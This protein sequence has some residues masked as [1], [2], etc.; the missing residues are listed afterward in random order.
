MEESFDP[1][2]LLRARPELEFWPVE[3][4]SAHRWCVFDPLTRQSYHVGSEE[5][6]LLT[7]GRQPQT[8][9][10]LMRSFR[11]A[12][13][14]YRG[15]DRELAEL[16]EQLRSVGLLRGE[17]LS[18]SGGSHRS[19]ANL[20]QKLIFFQV[21]GV[22]PEA[23][24][25]WLA[26]RTTAIFSRTAVICW[27]SLAGLSLVAVLFDSQRLSHSIA[28]L[29][30][31]VQP[32]MGGRLLAVFLLTRAVHELGHALACTRFGVRCPDIGF[33]IILGAPCVYCDVSESW[34]LPQRWKRAAVAAAGMYAELIVAT[35]ASWLW[36]WTAD[37]TLNALALQTMLVCSASTIAV[38]INP[39]MRFDGYYL[40]ADWLNETNLRAKADGVA[41]EE[42]RGAI[43]DGPRRHAGLS[44]AK[45]RFY[46]AFSA[47]SLLYRLLL[48]LVMAR[49]LLELF[50]AWELVWFGRTTALLLLVAW[51]GKP[52]WRL[53]L[54][55]GRLLWEGSVEPNLENRPAVGP[56]VPAS[57]STQSAAE[58]RPPRRLPVAS[59]VRVVVAVA[60]LLVWLVLVPLPNRQTAQGWLE[61]TVSHGVYASES[62][63]LADCLVADGQTVQA[64]QPLF[65][66]ESPVVRL[67][68]VAVRREL[69][70]QSIE[71]LHAAHGREVGLLDGP[72]PNRDEANQQALLQQ[73]ESRVAALSIAAPA[74]GRLVAMPASSISG[75]WANDLSGPSGTWSDPQNVGRTVGQGQ[76]L[77][78]VCSDH[79]RAVLLLDKHQLADLDEGTTARVRLPS[80]EF[81]VVP[82][83]VLSIVEVTE[84]D[85]M[86]APLATAG[87]PQSERQHRFAALVELP[88]SVC[89]LPGSLP[90]SQVD[91][92]LFGRPT[93]LATRGLRWL[94][95][96]FRSFAD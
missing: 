53:L 60:A 29:G 34:T 10:L 61:P 16:I 14:H 39:L 21:R 95:V 68:Q 23:W 6:W 7:H 56:S 59:R 88:D 38:N 33:F 92:V 81:V 77:A 3:D 40:L 72:P 93:S 75:P 41:R 31:L 43:G 19:P 62:A 76:L 80:A 57:A 51:W 86:W 79:L 87:R 71:R 67:Q 2:H 9:R 25:Q 5:K 32:T 50:A 52:S 74:A 30:W 20:L 49:V 70:R 85:G 96:N 47:A 28:S 84:V 11:V 45:R 12:H 83:Q 82:A 1:R 37:G 58:G 54:A 64:E 26:P 24:L 89:R 8:S 63:Q 36:L 65:Q 91:A 55:T 66:L 94:R 18:P 22:R 69:N 78:A 4:A 48:S 73:A 13:P 42:L 17:Q 15:S 90:G 27:L 46:V 35:L 44:A